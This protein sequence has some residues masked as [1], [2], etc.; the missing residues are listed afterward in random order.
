[1]C[2]LTKTRLLLTWTCYWFSP[3]LGALERFSQETEQVRMIETLVTFLCQF[4]QVG[5]DMKQ[6]MSQNWNYIL[7]EFFISY[8]WH[9]LN[10]KIQAM[11]ILVSSLKQLTCERHLC[12]YSDTYF[13]QWEPVLK[14]HP[15]FQ[16]PCPQLGYGVKIQQVHSGLQFSAQGTWW[17]QWPR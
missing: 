15:F 16:C 12:P 9:Y 6:T 14:C 13:L 1:M 17:I 3:A 7:I 10:L 11:H 8:L 4:N 2:W 5:L